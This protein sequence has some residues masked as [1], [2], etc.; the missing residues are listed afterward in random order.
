MIRPDGAV[1]PRKHPRQARSAATVEAILDASAHILE[2]GGLEALN[3]NAIAE[4]AGVSIGSL[5][6][7]FPGKDAILA[8]LIRRKRRT[9]LDDICG[10]AERGRRSSLDEAIMDLIRAGAAH[11]LEYPRLA[12]SLA[13]AEA[14]LP[15]DAETVAL[16]QRI[17]AE[18]ASVLAA[19]NVANPGMAARDVVA[20]TRGMLDAQGWYGDVNRASLLDRIGRAITGYLQSARLERFGSDVRLSSP[21]DHSERG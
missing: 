14:T 1:E 10:A 15:L 20:L 2:R 16:K 12:Q 18:V 7:Y 8:A 4:R 9:L 5:Y 13:Y 21:E 19:H 17:V 11:Q 6:Q 3:T